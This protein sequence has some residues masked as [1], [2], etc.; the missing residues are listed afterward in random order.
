M[1]V[2]GRVTGSIKDLVDPL[3][4]MSDNVSEALEA[5][6]VLVTQTRDAITSIEAATRSTARTL[7]SANEAL[8]EVAGLAGGD[9]A[10]GLDA[11]VTTVPA[12]IDTASVIDT[13]MRALSFVGVDYDP[14]VPLDDS[15]SDL[16]TILTPIPDQI[17]DQAVL[18]EDIQDDLTDI[19]T[20]A[21]ELAAVLLETRISL[22][23]VDD[24]VSD[25]AENAAR[26]A[27]AVKTIEVE[28]ESVDTAIRLVA[29]AAA[30]ALAVA[31]VTPLLIGL[32][33]RATAG[34]EAS[35]ND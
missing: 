9:I 25:A 12:L 13:T 14:D 24:I 4:E 34:L 22:M 3:A 8:G 26:A 1:I 7:N 18:L 11:A 27:A 32:H 6:Q 17:R 31:G 23:E 19:G 10:E 35:S 21:G 5:S 15:L 20:D 16:E 29:I 33:F 28:I 2:G 30:V